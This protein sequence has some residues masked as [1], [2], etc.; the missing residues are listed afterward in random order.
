M[1]NIAEAGKSWL[2]KLIVN[3]FHVYVCLSLQ[4]AHL[5]MMDAIQR[6]YVAE[7]AS[8]EKVVQAVR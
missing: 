1:N 8:I 3:S 5:A 2:D 7:V 4:S 6:A